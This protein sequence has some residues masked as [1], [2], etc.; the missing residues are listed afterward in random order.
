MFRFDTPLESRLPKLSNGTKKI[1]IHGM[2]LLMNRTLY[3]KLFKTK[4]GYAVFRLVIEI[5]SSKQIKKS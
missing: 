1:D 3:F 4:L 2:E 5:L